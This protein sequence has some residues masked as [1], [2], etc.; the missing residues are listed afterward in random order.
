MSPTGR[1]DPRTAPREQA[2][3]VVTPSCGDRYK[4][5]SDE[6][7]PWS[8]HA[9]DKAHEQFIATAA[10]FLLSLKDPRSSI[11]EASYQMGGKKEHYK[12]FE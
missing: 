12:M 11:K 3:K 6:A 1:W 9:S 8:E 10:L 2:R 4:S 5:G 7:R